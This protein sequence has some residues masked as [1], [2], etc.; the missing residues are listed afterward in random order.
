MIFRDNLTRLNS[1]MQKVVHEITDCEI[2]EFDE[3]NVSKNINK[4]L[5]NNKKLI[6]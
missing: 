2:L 1:E 5:S 6:K 4:L 3:K